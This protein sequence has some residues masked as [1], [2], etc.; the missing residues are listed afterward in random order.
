MAVVGAETASTGVK[1]ALALEMLAAGKLKSVL[2]L[3]KSADAPVILTVAR[4]NVL[5]TTR[6][7]VLV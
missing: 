5:L 3:G 1:D 7:V 6:G 2:K 4:S